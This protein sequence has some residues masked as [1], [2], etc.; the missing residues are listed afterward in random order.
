[1]NHGFVPRVNRSV[2]RSHRLGIFAAA[3]S[4]STRTILSCPDLDMLPD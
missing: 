1:M 2:T 3:S 4:V